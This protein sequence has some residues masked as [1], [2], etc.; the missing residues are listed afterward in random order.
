MSGLTV[1][2]PHTPA[3]H[4]LSTSPSSSRPAA[5]R[6]SSC[7]P[8]GEHEPSPSGR[9]GQGGGGGGWTGVSGGGCR[10]LLVS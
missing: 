1:T 5:P 3:R 6:R 9:A 10:G 2:V 8:L 4:R 7:R